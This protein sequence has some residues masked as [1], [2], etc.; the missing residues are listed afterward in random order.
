MK[1][2]LDLWYELW[3]RAGSQGLDN[4]YDLR[5]EAREGTG[6]G[7]DATALDKIEDEPLEGT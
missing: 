5:G 7:P 2:D 3:D 6:S 4:W 1:W